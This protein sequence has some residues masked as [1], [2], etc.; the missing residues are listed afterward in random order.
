MEEGE[1][2]AEPIDSACRNRNS[3]GFFNQNKGHQYKKKCD[4]MIRKTFSDLWILKCKHK[5]VR[6]Y[7]RRKQK[8]N[9]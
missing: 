3:A 8:L 6:S 4:V 7:T 9:Y 5:A 1:A 2:L